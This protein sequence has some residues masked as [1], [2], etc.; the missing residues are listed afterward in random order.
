MPAAQRLTRIGTFGVGAATLFV[1]MPAAMATCPAGAILLPVGANLR[2]VVAQSPQGASFCIQK[3]EHRLQ[4]IDP[5][6]DQKFYGQKGA[7]LNGSQ[8]I[9][10]FTREGSDWVASNQKQ[11]G[12]RKAGD[13]C[14][15]GRPRCDRPEAFYIDDK[16]LKAVAS[17]GELATGKFYFDYDADKIYFRNNPTGHKVE[18]S[19]KPYAFNGGATGVVID[20]LIVEKYSSPIQAGAIGSTIAS[21]GWTVRNNEV[22]LNYGVGVTVGTDS[23]I[24]NNYI[25][26]NGEMGIGCN[27]DD[28]LIEG[29]EI[30]KNGYFAGLDPFWEGGGGKC[31]QTRR[32][33]VRNNYSHHNNA[34]GFWTDIDNID[35]LYEKNRI[36]HNANGGIS[37]EISY[38]ATI[39]NNT[40]KGNGKAFTVW[41][42]GG[43]IQIQNSRDVEVYGN[44]IDMT[45]A[46]NGIT[47]IQQNRGTGAYGPLKTVNN[48]IHNNKITSLTPDSGVSGAIADDDP[49]TMLSGGNR[50]N[51][52]TYTGTSGRDEHWAWV[53]DFY[54]WSSYRQRSG[55]DSDSTLLIEQA[56]P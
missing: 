22:R 46:G 27:G 34:M 50:F 20:G 19:V 9:K 8:L 2:Q 28:I 53:T 39:R 13:E 47:L 26:R 40:F 41:L 18:A 56:A 1:G 49:S 48:H 4:E 51:N 25:H 44:T 55:Q 31:A 24:L 29:N 17:R 35:T 16:P 6:K 15:P 10:Q 42:W 37:H 32:L 30:A 36:A 14:L 23:R 45:D 38:K 54:D 12:V 52:N 11:E 33:I 21:K 7:I 5:K 43:A 3:G